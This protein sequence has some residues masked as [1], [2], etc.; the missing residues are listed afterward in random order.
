MDFLAAIVV[1]ATFCFIVRGTEVRLAR[2]SAITSAA[3][4]GSARPIVFCVMPQSSA[5]IGDH[6]LD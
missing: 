3:R 6:G 4:S 5:K 1:V 2:S